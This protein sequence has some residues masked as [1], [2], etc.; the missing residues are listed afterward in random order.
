MQENQCEDMQIRN[1]LVTVFIWQSIC[2]EFKI[3]AI[4]SYFK[5]LSPQRVSLWTILY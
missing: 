5:K 1:V 3:I 4:R 2:V